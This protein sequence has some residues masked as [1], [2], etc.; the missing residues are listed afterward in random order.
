M[1]FLAATVVF[2]IIAGVTVFSIG[3]EKLGIKI[4]TIALR[5]SAGDESSSEQPEPAVTIAIGNGEDQLEDIGKIIDEMGLGL[6]AMPM[7][8]A[9]QSVLESTDQSRRVGAVMF[10]EYAAT[11]ADMLAFVPVTD[12]DAFMKVLGGLG[13]LTETSPRQIEFGDGER[14]F[15]EQQD[16]YVFLGN[17]KRAMEHTDNSPEAW[18]AETAADKNA[19]VKINMAKI[20]SAVRK[21]VFAK[22]TKY[23]RSAIHRVFDPSGQ[24]DFA[25]MKNM[26]GNAIKAFRETQSCTLEID[27]DKETNKLVIDVE[28][29]GSPSSVLGRTGKRGH[30][31]PGSRF[32][33]FNHENAKFSMN[34]CAPILTEQKTELELHAEAL[35]YY[36]G[37]EMDALFRE[38]GS[39]MKR[40]VKKGKYDLAIAADFEGSRFNFVGVIHAIDTNKFK[41]LLGDLGTSADSSS[42]ALNPHARSSIG[43]QS[44]D[45]YR[46]FSFYRMSFSDELSLMNQSNASLLLGAGQNEILLGLGTRPMPFMKKCIDACADSPRKKNAPHFRMDL[47]VAEMFLSDAEAGEAREIFQDIVGNDHVS[48]SS[49]MIKS[50]AQTQLIADLPVIGAFWKSREI[51]AGTLAVTSDDSVTEN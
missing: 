19:I 36:Q 17:T 40:T 30:K 48:V 49:R 11:S 7:K 32:A 20:P 12:S 6:V 25:E 9:I 43:N 51:M 24:S 21:N 35:E 34:I 1:K 18:L 39:V 10:Y 14:Y 33:N 47:N 31:L 38:I 50:G 41:H 44:I 15:V 45:S 37:E 13:A 2:T 23:F 16:G 3:P 42:I 26:T 27:F 5:D 28:N 4:P 46:G 29:I 8:A 22:Y